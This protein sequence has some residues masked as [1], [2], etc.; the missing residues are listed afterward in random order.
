MNDRYQ[1][2]R[3]YQRPTLTK[4]NGVS[5]DTEEEHPAFATIGASR[6][7][8]TPGATLFGSDFKHQHFIQVT[9]R[10]A[11]MIRSLSNDWVHGNEQLIEVALSESQW[12]TFLST[13]N[14]GTGIPCT[15][16]WTPDEGYVPGILPT[17]D[18]RA[19]YRGDIEEHVARGIAAI[20][21]VLASAKLSRADRSKLEGAKAQVTGHADWVTQ[22]F[23]EH[24]EETV[25]QA[26]HEIEAYLNAAVHRAGVAAIQAS[27][28]ALELT[29]G[30][31]P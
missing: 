8:S 28:P 22:Q 13:L 9:I 6:V 2:T 24:S 3:T 12:A 16:E 5:R 4:G 27:A 11:R 15:L 7:S 14:M 23:D 18:R 20:D 31:I 19:Q 26:K 21:E 1:T 10:R 17:Q 25:E 30:E 29:E